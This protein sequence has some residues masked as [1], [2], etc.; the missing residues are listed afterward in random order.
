MKTFR[1]SRNSEADA[2]EF[3]ENLK[4]MFLRFCMQCAICSIYMITNR[5]GGGLECRATKT[6]KILFLYLLKVSINILEGNLNR[7]VCLL[8][9]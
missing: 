5:M 8:L 2:S 6:M 3:L 7:S 9:F 4:E 1:F